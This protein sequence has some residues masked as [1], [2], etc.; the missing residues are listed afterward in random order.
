MNRV[1]FS[2][3]LHVFKDFS[4]KI[5]QIWILGSDNLLNSEPKITQNA[6]D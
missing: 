6:V 4:P 5:K 1:G 2:P 3:Y